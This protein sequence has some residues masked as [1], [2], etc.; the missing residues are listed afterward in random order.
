VFPSKRIR[1]GLFAAASLLSGMLG[2]GPDASE[3]SSL[4]GFFEEDS[5]GIL[6]SVTRDSIPPRPLGWE[7]DPVPDL[8]IGAGDSPS[9]YLYRVQGVR[10]LA[11]GGFLVLDGGSQELRFFDS[12]GH[13]S[14]RIGGSGEGPGEFRDPVLVPWPA[15]DS[16][17]VF[18]KGLP[19]LQVFPREV[20][21]S[22]TIR[23]SQ[24]PVG[25][26]PPVGAVTSSTILFQ[27]RGFYGGEAGAFRTEGL[28]RRVH[29]FFWF[30]PRS[31][32]KKVL[33]DS[34]V[35]GQSYR[36]GPGVDAQVWRLPFRPLPAAV[37]N[38]TGAF[39]SDGSSPSIM[40]YDIEGRLR[41]IFRL[42]TPSRPITPEMVSR[43]IE[44]MKTE[45]PG[46]SREKL[47]RVYANIPLPEALPPFGSLHLDEVGWLWAEKYSWDPTKPSEWVLFDREGRARG[48]VQTPMG[49]DIEW[50][51][52]EF[53]LGVF[54]DQLG[55]EYVHRH[56]IYRGPAAAMGPEGL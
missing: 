51:G 10:G 42:E 29:S 3:S 27:G 50:I 49:L 39:I 48:T 5:A 12:K 33:L 2:C 28:S 4:P 21:D 55:I 19:R 38:D 7:I 46:V 34:I 25:R 8:V 41:R 16:L 24:W 31:G 9:E 43:V 40:E 14:N 53:L 30:H 52:R 20:G 23:L 26:R 11:N 47:E 45:R 22:I 56:S 36:D 44:Q 37:V 18:D 17:L 15:S 35:V 1:K 54:T 32:E 6:L 13:L